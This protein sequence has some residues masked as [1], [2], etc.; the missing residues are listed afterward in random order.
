LASRTKA[1]AYPARLPTDGHNRVKPSV[2]LSR[3]V[4]MISAVIASSR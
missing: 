2:Y 3:V 4:P 1:T